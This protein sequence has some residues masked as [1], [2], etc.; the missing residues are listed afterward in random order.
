MQTAGKVRK[1]FIPDPAKIEIVKKFT[2]AKTETEAINK[3]LDI[4]IA[5]EK[6]GKALM[7]VKGKEAVLSEYKKR[8]VLYKLTDEQMRKKYG[9]SLNEFDERNVVKEKDF[10]WEVETD[11]MNWEHALEGI[12]NL[13]EKIKRLEESNDRS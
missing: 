4:I 6:I 1:Q 8:I 13:Q 11:A 7:T 9:M 3:A 10:S 5:N 2:H 12:R